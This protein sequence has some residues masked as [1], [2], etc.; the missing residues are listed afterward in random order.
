MKSY[1]LSVALGNFV[2]QKFPA[3]PPY[4][5]P[6][7]EHS[8]FVSHDFL[9]DSKRRF[10]LG[11]LGNGQRSIT[12]HLAHQVLCI[13]HIYLIRGSNCLCQHSRVCVCGGGARADLALSLGTRG[14]LPQG[15]VLRG[16]NKG[17]DG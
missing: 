17:I 9:Q 1:L 7:V 2:K 12:D 5:K 10:L 16:N 14:C 11:H 4:E 3:R 15:L 8:V 13:H 6:A